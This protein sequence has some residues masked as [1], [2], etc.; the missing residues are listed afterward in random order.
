MIELGL[1]NVKIIVFKEVSAR[2]YVPYVALLGIKLSV[3]GLHCDGDY[4]E[5]C[6]I[7]LRGKHLP[8]ERVK[9]H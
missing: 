8:R 3:W 6:L 7:R 1:E 5:M 2:E 4:E 9:L